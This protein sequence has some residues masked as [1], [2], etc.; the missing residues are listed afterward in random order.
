MRYHET[1]CKEVRNEGRCADSHVAVVSRRRD[2]VMGLVATPFAAFPFP[3]R[4]E[5]RLLQQHSTLSRLQAAHCT[6]G[7]SSL[8]RG[9]RDTRVERAAVS[10][11]C[12]HS[13]KRDVRA[14]NVYVHKVPDK[15]DGPRGD[16]ERVRVRAGHAASCSRHG[17]RGSRVLPSCSMPRADSSAPHDQPPHLECAVTC[18]WL[19]TPLT[20][21]L[22]LVILCV[23]MTT[24]QWLHTEEK[25]ANP[26]YNGTGEKDYLSKIT[27]SG[28]WT[29]CFSNRE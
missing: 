28:L 2:D 23:A 22:S 13:I 7:G 18:L 20:A 8:A 10:R 3:V 5:P 4:G 26:G 17:L 21:T 29:L 1:R 19:L 24:N 6:S 9:C 12:K 14:I 15:T 25:M 16:E 27:V 11:L